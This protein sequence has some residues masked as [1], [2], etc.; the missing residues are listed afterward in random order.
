MQ[1]GGTLQIAKLDKVT[2]ADKI[3][4]VLPSY[5]GA[6]IPCAVVFHQERM[7]A[8]NETYTIDEPEVQTKE[9]TLSDG[10]KVIETVTEQQER[11]INGRKV[12]AYV[13]VFTGK[14][15][16]VKKRFK[17]GELTDNR[18]MDL[19]FECSNGKE[20]RNKI[21]EAF[22]ELA[23]RLAAKS[24]PFTRET[25]NVTLKVDGKVISTKCLL[26]GGIK[27][28]KVFFKGNFKPELFHENL[29]K[30]LFQQLQDVERGANNKPLE[31]SDEILSAVG[32]T[33]K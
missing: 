6:K 23:K 2:N 15:K 27:L 31:V 14:M 7:K 8:Q 32:L 30:P 1:Q 13:P 16:Q 11:T 18:E 26:Y 21:G 33:K 10:S 12:I 22:N 5:G 20:L 4:P 3:E 19:Y 9:V 29:C 25:L 24:H 28:S 17:V